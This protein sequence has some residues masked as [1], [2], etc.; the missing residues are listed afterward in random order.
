MM[1]KLLRTKTPILFAA[2]LLALASAPALAIKPFTAD[3]LAS[4]MGL[5]GKGRMTLESQ[6]DDRWKYTLSIGSNGIQLNQSTV[7]E[8]R[9]GKW[10]PLSGTDSSLLLIKKTDKTATYD[11]NS[12]VATWSGDVKPERAGPVKLQPGDVDALLLNLA[13]ARDV[14]A[15]KPL[16]YRLVE[17]GRA[18][19]LSYK[20]VGKDNVTVGGASKPATKVV[21]T[22]DNKETV[23]WVVDGLPVPARILQRKDGKDEIDLRIQSVH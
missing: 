12:G 21:Y 17:D 5:Q 4:Y 6:G 20:V 9:D 18:K 2:A 16:D 22:S 10:R 3:Y 23:A 19:Q 15:G 14:A 13:L 11:W 1:T 7:F 8:D